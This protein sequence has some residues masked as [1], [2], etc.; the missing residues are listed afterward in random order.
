[1]QVRINVSLSKVINI[2]N[3]TR[4]TDAIEGPVIRITDLYFESTSH[5]LLFNCGGEI[6]SE[7]P[8]NK[9]G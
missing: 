2:K 4:S 7:Y 1:M 5:S 9:A 8:R 3:Q 6:G